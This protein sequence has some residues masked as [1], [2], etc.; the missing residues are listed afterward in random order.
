MSTM[1]LPFTDSMSALRKGAERPS[2][3]MRSNPGARGPPSQTQWRPSMATPPR[4]N[5]TAQTLKSAVPS[6]VSLGPKARG[7]QGR[8]LFAAEINKIEQEK[9]RLSRRRE[10]EEGRKEVREGESTPNTMPSTTRRHRS[11]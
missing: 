4:K 7:M 10:E 6:P 5:P 3:I 8:E 2:P 11:L 9:E 1:P